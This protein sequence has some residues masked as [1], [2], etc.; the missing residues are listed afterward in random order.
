MSHETV[1]R[2]GRATAATVC[3]LLVAA[4]GSSGSTGGSATSV[5][6]RDPWIRT[7]AAGQTDAA[8]YLT[9]DNATET[10]DA[11]VSAQVPTA[12]AAST[13]L[14]ETVTSPVPGQRRR[15]R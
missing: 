1:H 15:C 2:R 3:L 6:V 9:I 10:E 13:Q 11:L 4:C 5:M 7:P 12:V 8:I 14:H